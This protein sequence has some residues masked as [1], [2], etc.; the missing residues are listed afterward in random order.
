MKKLNILAWIF[1]FV[2][3]IFL[4][5]AF[6]VWWLSAP[7]YII[8]PIILFAIAVIFFLSAGYCKYRARK[9]K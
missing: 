4:F 8:G 7:G 9:S 2:S 5:F 3:G 6:G 1:A